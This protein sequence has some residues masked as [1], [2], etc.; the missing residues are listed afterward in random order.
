MDYSLPDKK[1]DPGKPV[2]PI[3]LNRQKEG[4]WIIHFPTR[5]VIQ[6]NLLFLSP[7]DLISFK[8]LS[9]ISEQVSTSSLR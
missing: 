9:V 5:K 2:I 3:S 8:K 1:G 4:R 6:E 7:L